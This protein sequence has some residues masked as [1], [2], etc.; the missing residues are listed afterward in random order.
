M[1]TVI[2]DRFLQHIE[3]INNFYK[4]H[5]IEALE[6]FNKTSLPES[7]NESWRK[8][9][10]NQVPLNTLNFTDSDLKTEI[11]SDHKIEN[12]SDPEILK[13]NYKKEI[14][15]NYYLNVDYFTILNIVLLQ[16]YNFINIPKN[17]K[18]RVYINHKAVEGDGFFPFT[19]IN[20]NE[21]S[22]V[23]IIE[24][25]RGIEKQALWNSSL[26]IFAKPNSNIRF[27]SLRY[28]SDFE[29]HFHRIR[30]I[31]YTD[32]YVHTSIFHNGGI[33]GKNFLQARLLQ[34]NTEFRGI[35]FFL[36][37]KGH[38]LNMEMD[39]QHLDHYE[40]SSLLYKTILKDRS[41]SVFIG[42][43]E[44]LPKVKGVKSHQLN[45]NL[46]LSKKAKAE[47]RPWLIVRSEDVN[48]EHG[49]TSGDLNDEAIFYLKTRGF[50]ENQAK[51]ILM[52]G[53]IND[54]IQESNLSDLE[55]EK[56]L[57]YLSNKL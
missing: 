46:I 55:K 11:I 33:L 27:T 10:L 4:K 8:I 34:S 35:G 42:K 30:V 21:N 41:H 13:I 52:I 9:H 17:T 36:G 50:D 40:N 32:S 43:L 23:E 47:S 31:Q 28:H 16:N 25:I 38:Y 26:Y 56:Y 53:F 44:T 24:E 57:E 3:N 49:A 20:V 18:D 51:K 1:Q 19:V 6:I 48:C 37:E 29:F 2:K 5:Q 14:A 15:N 54:L 39:I 45:H 7:Y 12:Y 22:S